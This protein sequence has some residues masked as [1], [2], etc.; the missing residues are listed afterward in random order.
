M[1]NSIFRIFGEEINYFV[2]VIDSTF[3]RDF[4]GLSL[5]V[6]IAKPVIYEDNLESVWMYAE[7][8][9]DATIIQGIGS[10]FWMF[11]G[12]Q[13][14]LQSEKSHIGLRCFEYNGSV[15]KYNNYPLDCDY[16]SLET[17]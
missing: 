14:S 2:S 16:M 3:Y 17:K 11:G 4:N 9:A 10:A 1:T 15:Y 5:K 12:Q 13:F 7:G 6:L 8:G